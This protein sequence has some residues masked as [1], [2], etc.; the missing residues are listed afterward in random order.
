MQ[1]ERKSGLVSLRSESE[2]VVRAEGR[3]P[4]SSSWT[5]EE[6][7]RSSVKSSKSAGERRV[8]EAVV[9]ADEDADDDDAAA[10]R[11]GCA[12]EALRSCLPGRRVESGAQPESRRGLVLLGLESFAALLVRCLTVNGE[13]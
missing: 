13:S 1:R 7:A 10:L 12:V 5:E 3:E 2:R 11:M 4:C 6:R 9:D 8:C